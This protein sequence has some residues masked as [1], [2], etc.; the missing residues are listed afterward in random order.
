[1]AK[2]QRIGKPP[3]PENLEETLNEEQIFTLR[4]M[5]VFG[6]E[7]KFIR[8]P[9]FQDVLPVLFHTDSNQFGV[10]ENDGTLNMQRD[11]NVRE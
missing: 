10:L 9:L 5:E 11:L 6:W 1:M 3:V 4:R 2:E 8:R 7:L